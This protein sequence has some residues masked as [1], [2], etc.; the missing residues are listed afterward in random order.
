METILIYIFKSLKNP[1]KP[2]LVEWKQ[3]NSSLWCKHVSGALETSLVEWKRQADHSFLHLG[4][5][6][7]TSLVEWKPFR[8][9]LATFSPLRL[10]NFLSGIET[11]KEILKVG[12]N[13]GLGNFLSGMETIPRTGT[14]GSAGALGNF[15]SG[16]ETRTHPRPLGN[17][18]SGMETFDGWPNGGRSERPLETSLVEWKRLSC[19]SRTPDASPWK[20]P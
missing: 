6:L 14:F 2:S 11:K 16:M 10:G 17:F 12:W 13:I 18:L 19:S 15:L 1:L 7:E 9:M 20:L 4:N 8:L 5:P 3:D